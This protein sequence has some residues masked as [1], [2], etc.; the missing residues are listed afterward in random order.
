MQD[1][2]NQGENDTGAKSGTEA[3]P[4]AR[5]RPGPAELAAGLAARLCHDFISPAGAIASGIDLIEDPD[6]Q[7]MRED[8]MG[9]I[10]D[11]SKKL[12]ILLP[13]YRVAFGASAA[14]EAFDVRDLKAMM[15]GVYAYQK[16]V[17]TWDVPFETLEKPAARALLNLGQLGSV[18]LP[19]GG[20]ANLSVR[21][22]NDALILTLAG[23]GPR[24]NF[25]PEV[26]Q[27]LRGEAMT[28]GLP[29][30]WVQAY[31]LHTFV[32][33][34]GGEVAFDITDATVNLSVRLPA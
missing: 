6:S 13:F 20:A 5:P 22:E 34:A 26:R 23:E 10:A 33:D 14:A 21:R 17:L 31:Y 32:T 19:R 12:G 28:E 27:G 29:G 15:E 11:S 9:L 7:D 25:K 30:Y 16:A 1:M 2:E 3:A 18:A 24:I 4:P 8:A